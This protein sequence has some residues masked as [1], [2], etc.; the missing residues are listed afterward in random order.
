MFELT[1]RH[2]DIITADVNKAD[3]AFSHLKYDLIDHICCDLENEMSQGLPFEKA[4]EIIKK[5]IGIRGLQQIQVDT[6]LLIDK[7]YRIMKNTM[8]YFGVIAPILI[9]FGALF[10]TEHWPAAG[11]LITLGFFLLC[12]V[13][14]PSAV[15]V[16]YREVSNRKKLLAHLSGFLASFLLGISFLFKIQHWSGAGICMSI[17]AVSGFCFI[18][19][20][21]INQI[22]TS[23]KNQ[24]ITYIFG[25]VGSL[26]YLAGFYFKVNH[27]PGASIL[28]MA[29]SLFLIVV[30]FPLF[31]IS[32]YK[33]YEHVS[34]RFVFITF[35]VVWFIVPTSLISI[36]LSKDTLRG[37][38][39]NEKDKTLH[40]QYLT[41]RNNQLFAKLDA[42]TE[43]GSVKTK[44]IAGIVKKDAD[45]LVTYIQNIKTKI[46]NIDNTEAINSNQQIDIDM[47]NGG[48]DA[49][50][51][52]LFKEA[53][54]KI[55]KQ[56]IETFRQ[57]LVQK[58]SVS[59]SLIGE[60]LTTSPGKD[61]TDFLKTWEE[62]NLKSST[63]ITTINKL[64]NLQEKV[65]T[66]ECIVLRDLSKKDAYKHLMALTQ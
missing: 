59:A 33:D 54:A 43:L 4:Y 3:I 37:L 52:I 6:L 13:F 8:K 61:A 36:N 14:L 31:V 60:I 64:S 38:K 27:L 57:S 1:R 9:A 46:I 50:L 21:F 53:E 56:K 39:E 23:P 32:H 47:L 65:L 41:T 48:R 42:G 26:A 28:T 58:D 22:K 18:L 12:F 19:A 34:S 62:Y 2:L 5:R 29:G 51:Q 35:A 49:G 25:L 17:A 55:I 45:N 10:K 40:I 24:K 30:A 66:A 44:E 16:S 15:Y 63:L 11:I 20:F 7:K